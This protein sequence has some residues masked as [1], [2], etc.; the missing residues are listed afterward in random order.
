MEL[1]SPDTFCMNES[2][3][4][5]LHLDST[6]FNLILLLIRK[7]EK[8]RCS[9]LDNGEASL[10]PVQWPRLNWRLSL[11]FF[12]FFAVLEEYSNLNKSRAS[13]LGIAAQL[14][15]CLHQRKCRVFLWCLK[16]AWEQ[17]CCLCDSTL[18]CGQASF[19]AGWGGGGGFTSFGEFSRNLNINDKPHQYL[20]CNTL[21][22]PVRRLVRPSLLTKGN[23][24][25][26]RLSKATIW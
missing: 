12:F 25:N 8:I 24:I 15:V 6:G 9:I 18:Q 10:H 5:R 11:P 26:P 16:I 14:C 1:S 23:D 2:K 7:E 4:P 22:N 13:P 19:L 21:S 3:N 20:T 17:S